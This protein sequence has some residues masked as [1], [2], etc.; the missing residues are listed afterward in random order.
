[1]RKSD[2]LDVQAP[3]SAHLKLDRLWLTREEAGAVSITL[4][5]RDPD[6]PSSL[7]YLSMTL[8]GASD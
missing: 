1:M 6:S 8:Q 2:T 5:L 7:Y 3:S 4:P